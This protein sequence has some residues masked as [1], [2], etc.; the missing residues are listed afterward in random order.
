MRPE[1][2]LHCLD[3]GQPTNNL[4]LL[5]I[6]GITSSKWPEKWIWRLAVYL[7]G[8]MTIFKFKHLIL[9]HAQ[10]IFKRNKN[11][12]KSPQ[13]VLKLFYLREFLL[14]IVAFCLDLP[15]PIYK[16]FRP[17]D[18]F[19]TAFPWYLH[20]GVALILLLISS[21]TV[22]YLNDKKWGYA[23]LVSTLIVAVSFGLTYAFCVKY[24]I[25][26]FL[27]LIFD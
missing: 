26:F 15:Y 8:G 3:L 23:I 4:K 22:I 17:D 19:Y 2:Q 6:T 27:G 10:C 16:N 12:T 25:D 13:L 20:I 14:F 21:G 11:S 5:T 18:S 24:R 1:I 9:N 7:G